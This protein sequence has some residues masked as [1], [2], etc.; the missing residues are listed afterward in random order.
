M[1]NKYQPQKFEEKW[2][3]IWEKEKIYQTPP[4]KDEKEKKQKKYVLAMFP[5]PSGAGL[6]VG[7]VRI[8]TGTDVLARYF[9]MNGYSVLHPMGWDAFGLPAENAAI[10]AKKNPMEMVPDHINNF[11]RQMKRLGFS[12]DWQREFSTTDPSYYQWTQWLFLQF[13]KM[14]L[15]EKK[16]M[17]VYY[18]PSC[19]TGLAEEEVLPDATHERCGKPITRKTLPQ[20]V[21]KITCYADRLLADL[22]GLDWPEGILQMQKNWIG[23]SEGTEIKFKVKNQKLKAEKEKYIKVFTT[24]ADTLFGVTALVVAPE[25]WLVK[26]ILNSKFEIGNRKLEEIKKYV[27][28]AKR[29]LDLVRTDLTKEKTGVD[30]GLKAIHPLTGEEI[31]IFVA[32]YV[33]GWYGEGAVMVVPAHDE[34]DFQ[35][36][37]KFNL[38]IKEVVVDSQKLKVKNQKL[39][40][41]IKSQLDKAFTDYGVLINSGEFN[42]LSS[43]EAIEKITQKLQSLNLGQKAVQY[44]LRDWIF[45]RQRYWGEPIPMVYCQNCAEN[46]INYWLAK[47]LKSKPKAGVFIDDANMFYSQKKAGWRV[48]YHKIKKILEE[49]FEVKFFNYYITVPKKE[50]S[51]YLKTKR[52]L[53][54]IKENY[55]FLAIKEKSLKYIFDPQ[56]KR[57]IKKGNVDTEITIDALVNLKDLDVIVVL[58]GDSDYKALAEEVLRQRKKIVFIGF[59]ENMAWELR[60][61]KHLYLNRIRDSVD[62]GNKKAPEKT[63]VPLLNYLYQKEFNLSRDNLAGWFPIDESEL[64]LKLPYVASYEPT[65]TGESPL[66]KIKEFVETKCPNC[67][68]PARRETDTMP[69]W[70]GSCWYFIRFAQNQKSKIKN[71]KLEEE[72]KENTIENNWLPVDWYLGGAEHAVLHLLYSRFWVKALYDLGFLDFKEPFLRL[73]NVGM[74]LAED[75]RKMSKSFGNVINPDDVVLEYG[76]DALRL[77]EMFMAPF[78]SEIAWSTK[79]L[80]GCYRFLSRVW[81]LY[82]KLKVKS[83]IFDLEGQKLKIEEDKGLLVKLNKTIKKVTDDIKQVKFNTAI[84]AMMEFVNAWEEVNQG[85]SPE[86]SPQLN[87]PSD[88]EGSK[89][90]SRRNFG[91]LPLSAENAK[92]FLQLLAPFAPFLTEEIW[93]EVFGEKTSIHLSSW[94][95]I[96]EE[97]ADEE[98][99]IPVQVNGKLRGTIK[100]KSPKL[101]VKSYIEELALKQEKVK[102]YLEGKRYQLVYVKGKVV[103]FVVEN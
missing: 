60:Q 38:P 97:I 58:S 11:R 27:E 103:N 90:H 96:E 81:N 89:I 44:K 69:N 24:R 65:E 12:Y 26:D 8:Y 98:I 22:E 13:F 76:A 43:K 17:P 35:F 28:E 62:L 88:S 94:P 100:V 85:I 20:W 14:G 99:T 5:Y 9:R 80:Q 31:P 18:C 95:K 19:K 10:K 21:F 37:K 79:A 46:K 57:M 34:R 50:D 40:L 70:A 75:H 1:S 83:L 82:Q 56:L 67:G 63:G 39:Q 77:Y 52:Y 68:G 23:R 30:T 32:D 54:K 92:K 55:S 6:H 16:E 74:V 4:L 78:S 41:K 48:D 36:A 64:P 73:R 49:N 87:S 29:K 2:V 84:A 102:K 15:L 51:A 66:S 47:I 93:R 71:Q 72:W 42:G 33:L 91:P 59:E 3:E 86:I 45:S 7:H 25:H 61:I 53:E 101:K